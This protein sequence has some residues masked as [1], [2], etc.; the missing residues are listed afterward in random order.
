[1][2]RA[3]REREPWLWA[4]ALVAVNPYAV[5]MHRKIWPPS[6]LPVFCLMPLAGWFYRDRRWGAFAWGLGGMLAAQIHVGG[7]F[8]FAGLSAWTLVAPRIF[9]I[10]RRGAGADSLVAR[11]A[12]LSGGSSGWLGGSG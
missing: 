4:A 12:G 3:Q 5:L 9:C 2:G 1:V 10:I 7:L 6:A 11:F 8:F